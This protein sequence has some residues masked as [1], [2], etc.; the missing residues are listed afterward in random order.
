VPALS[1]PPLTV[2]VVEGDITAQDV[3]AIVNAANNALWMG[4]GVA[5]AIKKRG[6]QVIEREAM[7]QGPIAAGEAV[8][9]SAGALPMRFVIHAAAMDQTLRTDADRI[10]RATRSALE[11][12]REHHVTSIAFPALGTGVGGFPIADCAKV[13]LQAVRDHAASG[14]TTI[15]EVRFVLFGR[16]AC[17]TFAAAL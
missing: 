15:R 3:E 12:A 2:T 11:R 14:P 16:E 13:M 5:G 8:V 17:E 1:I 10:G 7:A 4:S 9:T 6:G